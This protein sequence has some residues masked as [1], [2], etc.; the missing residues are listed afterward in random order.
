M[1]TEGVKSPN[2]IIND[3]DIKDSEITYSVYSAEKITEKQKWIDY[4]PKSLANTL[5]W[6]IVSTMIILFFTAI[7]LELSITDATK[8]ERILFSVV[9]WFFV[10]ILSCSI[11]WLF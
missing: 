11:L 7:F 2:L 6:T 8:R 9:L 10:I 5:K 3:R 4:F 1:L